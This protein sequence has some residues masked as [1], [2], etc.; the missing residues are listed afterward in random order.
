[1]AL[2]GCVSPLAN[3]SAVVTAEVKALHETE[4]VKSA[5]DAAD[6]PAIW[7]NRANPAASLIVATDKKAGLYVYGLDGRV[8]S[9]QSVGRVNNVDLRDDVPMGGTLGV[10]VGA[11]DRTDLADGK[12]ALFRL[13]PVTQSLTPLG[14]IH[15]GNGEAYGFC[16]W[17]RASDR[18]LFAFV[19]MKDGLVSQLRLDLSGPRPRG[20]V[21]R[22]FKLATQS[23][24]CV[25][26]DRTGLVYIAEEDVGLWKVEADPAA[27]AAPVK[28]AQVDGVKLVADVEGLAIAAQGKRD[29]YLVVSSQGDSAYAAYTLGD[30]RYAGRF[31]IAAGPAIG[32]TSDTDGV[33]IAIGDFGPDFPN[34]LMVAQDGDNAPLAQ[35]FKI[36]PWPGVV[37]ALKAST[38][39]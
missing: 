37:A 12:A 21:V 5:E 8:R 14:E 38:R 28:F 36:V 23:E 33:E 4:A 11:S 13:D 18:A 26:D 22:T 34:G 2:A 24:G 7:R 32:A 6:D 10:L 17:R 16:L 9:F 3:P 30:G 29:G 31:R 20:D 27:V 19:V 39:R 15:A 25:A 35:N 1:M